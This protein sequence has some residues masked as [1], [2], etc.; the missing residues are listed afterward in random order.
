MSECPRAA[1]VLLN[2]NGCRD[3]LHCL[4]SLKSLAYQNHELVVVDNGS[5]DGLEDMVRE[6]YPNITVLQTGT[7][8]GFAGGNNVGIRYALDRG[9][10]YVWVLNNDTIVDSGALG[11]MVETAERDPRLGAVGS[12]IFHLNE[13]ERVQAWGGGR[14][15]LRWGI[16]RYSKGSDPA[17]SPH[18]ITGASLLIKKEALREVGLLDEDFFM[19][20]EDA[21][22]GF[23]L[24]KAGWSLATASDSHVWHKE[25]ASTEGSSATMDTYWNASAIRFFRKH[26]S[27]FLVP[28]IIGTGGR[29]LK[30]VARTDWERVCAVLR[31]V[32][33][34]AS[35]S[36]SR[37]DRQRVEVHCRAADAGDEQGVK[38]MRG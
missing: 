28:V 12:V 23:R 35:R 36:L 3:T 18:Y 11:A 14:V 25:F 15:D 37:G 31:G 7:N 20:W 16:S 17:D 27:V 6:V 29:I 33:N 10:D 1:V 38:E 19:Y 13:P 5:T 26:A 34:G 22:F 30:R 8:L 32:L 2:Y 24:R 4:A 21:D 9:A